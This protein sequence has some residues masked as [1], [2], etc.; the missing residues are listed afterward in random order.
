VLRSGRS[1]LVAAVAVV[2]AVLALPAAASAAVAYRDMGASSGPLNHVQVGVDLSCQVQHVGDTTFEFYPPAAQPGDCGTFLAD[3]PTGGTLY[4]PDFS[5]HDGTA[6]GSLGARTPFT[7]VSQVPSGAGTSA[8]P[9]KIVTVANAGTF[10]RITETDTYVPGSETYHTDVDVMNT[11]GGTR[12]ANI[13]RGGDCFLQDSD[14]GFGFASGGGQVGCSANPNN[15]PPNRIE[16]W[17]NPSAGSSFTEDE[18]STVWSKIG[19]HGIFGNDC[20]QCGANVDNGGGLSWPLTNVA[21]G[22][23]VRVSHNTTFSPTGGVPPVTPSTSTPGGSTPAAPPLVPP[24]SNPPGRTIGPAGNPLGLPS[25]RNCIDKRRF[26]FRLRRPAGRVV[27]VQ[28]FINN[29]PAG[30]KTGSNITRLTISRL[31]NKGKFKVRIVA[32]SADGTVLV[33]QRTYTRCKKSRVHGK[34]THGKRH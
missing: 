13:Y 5:N 28:I 7:P 16:E 4:T 2:A 15:S 26:S 18:Y 22:A 20:A 17:A 1:G 32:T 23:T 25:A 10:W 24:A 29:V 19:G 27:D 34:K 30:H 14:T 11:S 3:Q 8:D 31:P 21:N 33:S 12:S 6:T 9:F